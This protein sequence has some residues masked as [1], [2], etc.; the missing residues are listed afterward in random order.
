MSTAL[1]VVVLAA[2]QGKRMHSALP[3]VLHPLAGKPIVGHVIDA[4]QSL[5]PRTICV[6][7]GHGGEPVREAL[8]RPG[9][10][11][12]LQDPPRGTG[13]AVSYYRK[14]KAEVEERV[15]KGQGAV[16]E[17]RYR[18]LWDNIAIWYKLFR[19]FNLFSEAGA[20]FVV[21]TYTNAWST[22]VDAGDPIL[23]LARTYTT[24]YINQSL[25]VRAAMMA[26]LVS[27]FAVDGI[28]LH[29]NRSCKPYSLGQYELLRQVSERTGAP[30]LI[31]E[32]DMCDTRLYADEP[33]KNRIQAFLD[34]LAG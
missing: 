24:V 2:G 4:V 13:D 12:A 11:F 10:A 19:L 25:E 20:C 14:L 34:V 23:S 9:L 28:V 30:G 22:S 16:F 27:R 26:D 3:K 32:A 5:A 6:V 33:I 29:S 8:H 15:A 17:E 31:L 18:L 7:Y 21:D 1:D